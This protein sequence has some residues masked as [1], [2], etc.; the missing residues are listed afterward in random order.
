MNRMEDIERDDELPVLRRHSSI[1]SLANFK[2][3]KKLKQ[4]DSISYCGEFDNVSLSGERGKIQDQLHSFRKRL[5][6]RLGS[7]KDFSKKNKHDEDD[8]TR[9]NSECSITIPV[10][11]ITAII[12]AAPDLNDSLEI[13]EEDL[14]SSRRQSSRKE[15]P[16]CWLEYPQMIQKSSDLYRFAEVNLF[17]KL[18]TRMWT[19]FIA[20]RI[21]SLLDENDI[22][23]MMEVCEEWK[24]FIEQ[25]IPMLQQFPVFIS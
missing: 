8:F 23:N 2:A 17:T 15:I 7:I 6:K 19:R 12:H 3:K 5:S 11:E 22:R 9:R 16:I 21:I 18:T 20:R 25:S 13:E 10:P 24:I 4:Q 1:R 14:N